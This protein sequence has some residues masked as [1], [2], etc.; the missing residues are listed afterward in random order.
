MKSMEGF[1]SSLVVQ[2]FTHFLGL[3]TGLLANGDQGRLGSLSTAQPTLALLDLFNPAPVQN[4]E[5][6]DSLCS[7]ELS[8]AQKPSVLDIEYRGIQ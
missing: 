2:H 7:D 3:V 5:F 6:Q 4:L 8:N 1:R